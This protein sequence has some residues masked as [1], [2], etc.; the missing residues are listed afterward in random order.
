MPQPPKRTLVETLREKLPEVGT[1]YIRIQTWWQCGWH[2]ESR[3]GCEIEINQ[4]P[5]VS[6]FCGGGIRVHTLGRQ[7]I[8]KFMNNNT[9]HIS[10][11]ILSIKHTAAAAV[12]LRTYQQQCHDSIDMHLYIVTKQL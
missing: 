1:P 8:I 4:S 3:K 9:Q 6:E 10:L 7:S 11:S 5:K 2:T 12:G